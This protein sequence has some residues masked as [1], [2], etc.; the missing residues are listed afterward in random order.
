MATASPPRYGNPETRRDAQHQVLC[1]VNRERGFA[2]IILNRDDKR[3]ALSVPMRDRMTDFIHQLEADDDVKVIIFESV[4]SSF[5]SG[6]QLDEDWG[7]RGKTR[8]F[9]VSHA[10]L[11]HTQM[12]WGRAGFGQAINR[13]SKVTIAQVQGYCAAASY[14]LLA[15]RCDFIMVSEDARFG[16]L[17]AS[18]MGP[19]GA[20][21]SIHLN[22]I[23]GTKAARLVGYTGRPIDAH[24]ARRYGMAHGVVPRAELSAQV[25]DMAARIAAR[26]AGLLRYLKGRIRVGES[27][28]ASNVP[29]ISGLLSS[30]FIRRAPDEHNFFETA[31]K[32]GMKAALDAE[33][34]HR[35]TSHH[36]VG[37]KSN[38]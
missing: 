16:A 13:S 35:G 3:N 30:H 20:T 26:P 18:F 14:F 31:R 34:R 25:Q 12:T 23:L 24:A 33:Q 28:L 11:Y 6:A 10:Y 4:G 8:R 22:R 17:E 19:A 27:L 32:Q 5:S 38:A 9:T 2:R 1:E 21:A 36:E 7:Q 15:S 29:V 37:G